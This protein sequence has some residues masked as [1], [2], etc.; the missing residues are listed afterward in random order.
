MDS[1]VKDSKSVIRDCSVTTRRSDDAN[2]GVLPEGDVLVAL[3]SGPFHSS[4]NSYLKPCLK[5]FFSK[6]HSLYR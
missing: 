2:K 1:D 6:G 5:L 4:S 3:Y